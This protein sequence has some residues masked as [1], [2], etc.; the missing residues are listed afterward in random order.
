MLL[1]GAKI[2]LDFY[3]QVL[4]LLQERVGVAQL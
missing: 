4:P 2:D 1:H 3:D